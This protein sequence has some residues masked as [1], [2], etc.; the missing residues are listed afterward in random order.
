MGLRR[1]QHPIQ[2]GIGLVQPD[3][4]ALTFEQAHYR[5]ALDDRPDPGTAKFELIAK[6]LLE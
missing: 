6:G 3:S 2:L 1:V 5:S 4:D